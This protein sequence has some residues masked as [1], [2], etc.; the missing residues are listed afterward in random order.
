MTDRYTEPTYYIDSDHPEIIKF[1]KASYQEN[2][3]ELQ[4]AIKLYY[5][6]RDGCRYNPYALSI[7]KE[8]FKASFTLAAGEGFCIP[9]A[10]LLTAVTRAAGIPARL[11]FGNVKNHLATDRLKQ[12]M[13][14]DLFVFHGYSELFLNNRWVKATPAFNLE[15]C[16]KFETLPLE[17]DGLS[18][19]IFHPYDQNGQRHMEYLHDYGPFA[20]FPF[21][22]MIDEWK[23]YYPFWSEAL[24]DSSLTIEGDFEKEREDDLAGRTSDTPDESA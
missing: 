4:R 14:S 22:K 9:K 8:T 23:K 10:I 18:D 2:D 5:A 15:L 20:D 7:G 11:G 24:T 21:Q 3:P 16:K 13:G 12:L 1:A 17:F 19:S 6:V